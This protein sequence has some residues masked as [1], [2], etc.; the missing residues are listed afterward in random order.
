VAEKKAIRYTN[1][2]YEPIV[3]DLT[4]YNKN[5]HPDIG[6]DLTK[7][8]PDGMI[9][10]EAAY[11]GDQLSLNI[12]YAVNEA[13]PD[14]A[15]DPNNVIRHARHRGY[16]FRGPASAFGPA[17][18]YL[19]VP[20]DNFG[21]GPDRRY[22]P[23]LKRGS[24]VSSTDG[25]G[26][27]L[28]EDVDFAHPKNEIIVSEVDETTGLP[29][30]Y[31]V[32]SV[33][34]VIT[35]VIQ[36]DT[37]S[38]G[39]YK[40]FR[41]VLLRSNNVVEILF[42]ED[43]QGNEYYE[44][45]Y[46]SQDVVYKPVTNH[47]SST[48]DYA[49]NIL[50]PFPVPRR[51]KVI[52]EK[53]RTFLLFGHGSESD[54]DDTEPTDPAN[55]VLDVFGKDYISDPSFDPSKLVRSDKFG[56][57][58]SNTTL[59][60]LTRVNTNQNSNI[61]VGALNNISNA[62]FEFAN[63][64]DLDKSLRLQVQQSIEVDNEEPIIGDVNF[65]TVKELKIRSEDAY[66]A[67]NRAVTKQDYISVAYKMPGGYGAIKRA[68]IVQD[69]D[70]FRRNLNF[71]VVSEDRDG[72]LIAPNAMIKRNLKVW[73]DNFKMLNDTV[74]IL[75]ARIVNVG[76]NFTVVGVPGVSKTSILSKCV[77]SLATKFATD[78]FIGEPFPIHEIYSNLN[79]VE[80][81]TDTVDVEVI[82][83]TGGLYSSTRFNVEENTSPD[84]RF[85]YTP[86]DVI[87]EIKYFDTDLRGA[88]K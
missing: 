52:F 85:V 20:A 42:C 39:D 27:I 35:G 13:F 73:L 68:N 54:I 37:V 9:L 60:I 79:R 8:S 59:R 71:Y 78:F 57:A 28:I 6:K 22:L 87:L 84:G 61:R 38:L 66:A 16:N 75:D 40:K 12:D 34:Q 56:I 43:S 82:H 24:E 15:I 74:D 11:I 36:E 80:G 50:K 33:G 76:L 81:V 64:G 70:S 58:P 65:P 41:K 83:K 30:K 23:V 2:E 18:F 25:N 44:V 63:P 21:T 69:K 29:T 47:D 88:V 7:N 55:V 4:N 31:A 14:S 51:F 3:R 17:L 62:V 45:D 77:N 46:L 1:R 53:G 86:E 10:G 49:Q 32:K 67:Q 48:K 72:F 5:F 26:A 19:S